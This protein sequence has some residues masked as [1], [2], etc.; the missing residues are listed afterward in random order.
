MPEVFS[1]S[2]GL[3]F[4]FSD[5]LFGVLLQIPD[6]CAI[7]SGFEQILNLFNLDVHSSV[8]CPIRGNSQYCLRFALS[9]GVSL[10]WVWFWNFPIFYGQEFPS[11]FRA[12]S[13]PVALRNFLFLDLRRP[14]ALEE[15]SGNLHH[16]STIFGSFLVKSFDSALD[17]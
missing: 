4:L 14:L 17:L 3:T 10:E 2:G 7:V 15:K 1:F 13:D 5:V 6:Y 9:T 11:G 12:K 8:L 16:L